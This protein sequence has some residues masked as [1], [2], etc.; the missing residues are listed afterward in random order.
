MSS[1]ATDR[2]PAYGAAISIDRVSM[3]FGQ[4]GAGQ[5]VRA[6]H[7]VSLDVVGFVWNNRQAAKAA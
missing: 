5:Q 6:L 4:E 3:V 2:G 1:T 7:D